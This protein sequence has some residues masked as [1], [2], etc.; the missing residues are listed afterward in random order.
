MDYFALSGLVWKDVGT[1]PGRC[2]GLDYFARSGRSETGSHSAKYRSSPPP[3]LLRTRSIITP[4]PLH[5]PR[6]QTDAARYPPAWQG[7]VPLGNVQ[8]CIARDRVPARR[9]H[10][11]LA[12][13]TARPPAMA[14]PAGRCEGSIRALLAACVSARAQRLA[15]RSV[16]P[17]QRPPA[18]LFPPRPLPRPWAPGRKELSRMSKIAAG[19]PRKAPPST[20][21][22][23]HRLRALFRRA[24]PARITIA[25]LRLRRPRRCPVG[26]IRGT[27]HPAAPAARF[28]FHARHKVPDHD[29]IEKK[30]LTNR[31]HLPP[32]IDKSKCICYRVVRSMVLHYSWVE[33]RARAGGV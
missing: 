5:A 8:A 17:D 22:P 29:T 26:A 16:P 28:V 7:P 31:T 24:L 6:L 9:G 15:D 14:R 12:H 30:V 4:V 21:C 19:I 18:T 23:V 33:E 20:H 3:I 25:P 32:A 1:T 13:G 11:A 2:P 10:V 27:L